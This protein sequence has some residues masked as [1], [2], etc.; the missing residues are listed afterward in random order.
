MKSVVWMA[1]GL[2]WLH[3]GFAQEVLDYK[4]A[5]LDILVIDVVNER[6][7]PKE[8]KVTAKGEI[9]FP[10]LGNIKVAGFTAEEVQN[11]L[12]E[13]L[14]KEYLV[15]PQVI[16]Q[17][18]ERVKRKVNVTGQVFKQGPVEMPDEKENSLTILD[19]IGMAG[20]TTRL[21]KESSV[22]VTR[23]GQKPFE[24]NLTKL[25][26]ETDPAKMFILQAGDSI[27]VPESTF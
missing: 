24:V 21:A 25:R 9:P 16:V 18:K 26:K 20:G 17:V 10:Y 23:S 7:L 2:L 15:N 6:D 27:F 1:A 4:I 11:D 8:F 13:K 5:A 12:K 22:Q 14:E 19:A 3:S